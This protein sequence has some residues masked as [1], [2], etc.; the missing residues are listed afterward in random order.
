MCRT[1]GGM[2]MTLPGNLKCPV[3]LKLTLLSM[4]T[5]I[6]TLVCKYFQIFVFIPLFVEGK[7]RL[8]INEKVLW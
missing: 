5:D 8:L 1:Q 3:S 7:K 2:R 4:K 6:I